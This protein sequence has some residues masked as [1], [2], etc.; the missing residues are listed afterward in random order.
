[1]AL[2]CMGAGLL[3][4]Q[5]NKGPGRSP[6]Y[7]NHTRTPSRVTRGKNPQASMAEGK[8]V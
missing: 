2:G 5:G 1:M 3:N 7:K 4:T 8:A 6:R